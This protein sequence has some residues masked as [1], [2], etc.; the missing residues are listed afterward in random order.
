[1]IELLGNTNTRKLSLASESNSSAHG[2]WSSRD[3]DPHTKEM[4][5]ADIWRNTRDLGPGDN[6]LQTNTK[7]RCS[8]FSLT[9]CILTSLFS[10]LHLLIEHVFWPRLSPSVFPFM[11]ISSLPTI[12]VCENGTHNKST[13]DGCLCEENML[14]TEHNR[15]GQY[16]CWMWLHFGAGQLD[17]RGQ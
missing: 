6:K 1:M 10:F 16:A 11:L 5:P 13:C 2:H 4:A 7:F 12:C 8:L 15:A 9:W 3:I 14:I 17:Q